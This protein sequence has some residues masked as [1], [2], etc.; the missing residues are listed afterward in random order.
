MVGLRRLRT[1]WVTGAAATSPN[2]LPRRLFC[3]PLEAT[4]RA[5]AINVRSAYAH[6]SA[7]QWSELHEEL[8]FLDRT[9]LSYLGRTR[10]AVEADVVALA[11][12]I[13]G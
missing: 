6:E 10:A 5:D 3:T 11:R 1:T 13:L 8:A 4:T 9:E 2:L 12:L 7:A